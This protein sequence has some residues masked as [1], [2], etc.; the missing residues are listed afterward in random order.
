MYAKRL[1]NLKPYT[2]G[3]QP[4]DKQYIKLN[5]NENP[6]PPA[7]QISELLRNTDID[8]LRLYPDPKMTM[9]RRAIASHF[10]VSAD[11]VFVGNGS[12][13]VLSF[14][15]YAFFD[16]DRGPLLF[17]DITYSFYPVYCTFYSIE[18]STIAL[19]KDFTIRIDNFLEKRSSCGMIFPNPN[20]PTG[21]G[22]PRDRI[23]EL[24]TQ[25]PQDRVVAID[26]A[27]VDFGGER[28]IPL[29]HE[30]EN[31]IIT[32]TFSK[33]ASLA[34]AR[35]G[36]AIAD[37]KLIEQLFT[38]KDSFNSYPVGSLIQRIGITAME[39]W[40][41]YDEIIQKIIRTREKVAEALTRIGWIVYPSQ[42][43]FLFA[44]DPDVSGEFI[45]THL[46]ER[47]IGRAH[48]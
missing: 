41:Y 25:Y 28:C 36:F 35:L 38:V 18:Y 23:A 1:L 11:S 32:G 6:Y 29:I 33:S 21:I 8:T 16:S 24:L 7:P 47:E 14:I 20:A 39:N 45:Y 43:N 2:P 13:E 34:G 42:A 26:E 30:H 27:Y 44:G 4:Q 5:T 37:P 3:E 31:L 9:L 48:V 15:F 46:K 10:N 19:Q 17:P 40:K 22:L 12:D